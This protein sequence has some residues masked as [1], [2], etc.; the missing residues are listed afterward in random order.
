MIDR[1][2]F[3]HSNYSLVERQIAL[4]LFIILWAYL[5]VR[6]AYVPVL[7]DELATFFYYIQSDNYLPPNAHWDANNHVLNSFLSHVSYR[8]F[9][10]APLALRLPNVLSFIFLFYSTFQLSGRL[11]HPISRWGLLLAIT[12][13]P[14]LFEYLGECRGY[15]M[16]MAFFLVALYHLL[17][18]NRSL[19]LKAVCYTL[20]FLFLAVAANL[21]LII[22]AILII[23]LI[24]LH[25]ILSQRTRSDKL[26][27]LVFLITCSIFF[28]PLIIF[29]FKLKKRGA[30][31]YGGDSGFYEIT[32][33][34]IMKVF[35]HF[36]NLPIAAFMTLIF[37]GFI[38]YLTAQVIR[39]KTINALFQPA[40]S[41]SFL[42]VFT[43]LSVLITSYGLNVNFPEDRTGMH[44]FLLFIFAFA[45][46]L[47]RLSESQPRLIYAVGLLFYFPLI[48]L[49]HLSPTGSIFSTE[50]RTSYAIYNYI[51]ESK[52]TFKFPHLVGGY[53]TQELC[54]YYMNNRDGGN[55]GKLHTS[56]HIAL[57][58]DFQIVRDG[59]IIDSTLFDYYAPVL[60]DPTTK[61]TLF[62]RKNKLPKKIIETAKIVP[63]QGTTYAEYHNLLVMDVEYLVGKILYIGAEMTLDSPEQ[64]FKSWLAV[65]INDEN[66]QSLYSEHIALNWIRKNWNGNTNNVLQGTLLH[67]IPK[68][69]KTLKFFVWNIDKTSFSI[70]DGKYYLYELESDF[71][72]QY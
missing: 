22:P 31:Y 43:L 1:H 19:S 10:S 71:L 52:N 56:F 24:G 29:S 42:C 68:E 11:N 59:K 66:D 36:Y 58:A 41:F 49:Y 48:F 17:Q 63:T 64:P 34:S 62:E 27:Y 15:G 5:F 21:T 38:V 51:R 55:E 60:S 16:S 40:T 46:T 65:T 70:P 69:A 30:L 37:I 57:D 6:A 53:Q 8:F 28:L 18:F 9:G 4:A 44:L 47:D 61:L 35:T 12:C 2:Y 67:H 33:Q 25:F 26:V 7:H 72:N 32:V 14:Y 39:K 3:E 20:L 23:G 13:S 45:F 54:W 50:E